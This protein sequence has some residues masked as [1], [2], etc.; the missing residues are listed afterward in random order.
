[1]K[2]IDDETKESRNKAESQ[3]GRRGQ[4][5]NLSQWAALVNQ[6][7]SPPEDSGCD[8]RKG[9]PPSPDDKG[10][11]TAARPRLLSDTFMATFPG[12]NMPRAQSAATTSSGAPGLQ[13]NAA[14]RRASKATPRVKPRPLAESLAEVP[15]PPLPLPA[16]KV[17]LQR[18]AV[19]IPADLH[20]K[21]K[22]LANRPGA[23]VRDDVAAL[24]EW[25]YEDK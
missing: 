23:S 21:I 14:P 16:K 17:T 24:L 25:Y 5:K 3:K 18:L 13:P 20:A 2:K 4:G 12:S 6:E 9:R 11:G 19:D 8:E 10:K 15:A 1:M 7:V 22:R